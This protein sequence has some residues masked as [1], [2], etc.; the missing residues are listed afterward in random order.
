MQNWNLQSKNHDL[1]QFQLPKA[2]IIAVSNLKGGVGKTT[3]AVSLAAALAVKNRVLLVDLDSQAS[4]SVSLG[5]EQDKNAPSIIDAMLGQSPIGRV[6]AKTSIPGLTLL[7]ASVE[8]AKFDVYVANM[9]YHNFVLQKLLD[10][11]RHLFEYIILDCSPSLSLLTTNA[12]M[13]ADHY[14]TP[15]MPHLLAFHAMET[16]FH[17]L[18]EWRS[19]YK[20]KAKRLG[21][22]L[23]MVD[24][25]SNHTR[26]MVEQVREKYGEEVF[27]T[28][29][30]LNIKLAEAPS[31]GKSV[32]EHSAQSQAA[33]SYWE[34]TKE[35]LQRLDPQN[36]ANVLKMN[37]FMSN[38]PPR[39]SF[40]AVKKEE[41]PVVLTQDRSV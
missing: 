35:V 5:V 6:Y 4:A 18:E 8:L 41:L 1:S 20:I 32:M 31:T 23:T 30:K 15:V 29:I 27:K 10:A 24:S 16:F 19:T 7:P 33:Q 22:L 37:R 28:E 2:K 9:K 11:N 25:R 21:I 38:Q 12:M 39:Q 13:A 34:F 40:S 36:A 14:I 26:N 3:T 17:E